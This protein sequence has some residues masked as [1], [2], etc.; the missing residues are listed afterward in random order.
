MDPRVKLL[1]EFSQAFIPGT[2]KVETEQFGFPFLEE[3]LSDGVELEYGELTPSRLLHKYKLVNVPEHRMNELLG[4]HLGKTCNLCRYFGA[5]ANDAFCFNLDNN[6]KTDNTRV[7]PEMEL[8]VRMLRDCLRN[9][10]F[11]P[12]I[13]ASGRGYHVWCRLEQAADNKRADKLGLSYDSDGRKVLTG[14]NAGL[15]EAEIQQDASKGEVDVK[16]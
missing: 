11:E 7:I 12:L 9:L 4:A 13:V 5:E 14:R 16:P 2:V 8:A 10:E 1:K 6:R 3:L 15:T